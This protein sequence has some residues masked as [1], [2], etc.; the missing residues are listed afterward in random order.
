MHAPNRRRL[1][2]AAKSRAVG[3]SRWRALERNQFR[4]LIAAPR[5]QK[6]DPK[7]GPHHGE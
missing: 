7:E 1:N 4:G 6:T 2:G 3:I 5:R